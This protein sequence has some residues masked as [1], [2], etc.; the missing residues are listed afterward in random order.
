MHKKN[1]FPFGRKAVIVSRVS[2]D[3]QSYE[4][5]TQD[6][7]TWAKDNGYE[8]VKEFETKESGFLRYDLKEG[9]NNVT[10][11]FDKHP[12]CRILLCTEISRLSRRKA[13]LGI[14]QEYLEKHTI[15]LII[16]DIN[17]RLFND[18]G[19][20]EPGNDMIFSLYASMA[21]SE[22]RQKKERFRRARE[23]YGFHGYAIGGKELF[24][25]TRCYTEEK[26][27][28]RHRSYYIINK[29]EAEEIK[30]IYRWY[31][32]GIEGNPQQTSVRAITLRCIEE[33]MSR[34]LHSKRNVNKCL[35]EQAYIG[36]KKTHNRIKNPEYWVYK[37]Y[38]EPKYKPSNSFEYRYPCIFETEEE[39]ALF[40]AV[41][42]R[43]KDNCTKYAQIN[44]TYVDKS[45]LHTTLLAR[46]IHCPKCGHP[47]HGEYR[48]R[49]GRDYFIYR[50]GNN[51]ASLHKCSFGHTEKMELLDGVIYSVCENEI[52][53][54]RLNDMDSN[55]R[56]AIQTREEGLTRLYQKKEELNTEKKGI[57]DY[58]FSLIKRS[59]IDRDYV[60]SKIEQETKTLD[61][62]E[63]EY[64][65]EIEKLSAEIADL[66]T[67]ISALTI[68]SEDK[69]KLRTKKE[70]Y[71]YLHTVVSSITI[72]Y[73]TPTHT[74]LHINYATG[75]AD[76]TQAHDRNNSYICLYK[77]THGCHKAA[78]I[79]YNELNDTKYD[80]SPGGV[81]IWDS[82]QNVFSSPV[83]AITLD[84]IYECAFPAPKPVV[85]YNSGPK[86]RA[87]L[88]EWE[89]RRLHPRNYYNVQ[90]LPI[91]FK[92][93][94]IYSEDRR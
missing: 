36:V 65:K 40:A 77:N 92:M 32:Y 63:A 91:Q 60:K 76:G 35:K 44:G 42:I 55:L 18:D 43:I 48:I 78:L 26:I 24:G 83:G 3:I 51:R 57:I 8:V 86:A 4:P 89:E 84:E 54:L 19:V 94:D 21:Q 50:C 82:E 22:M 14:I 45:S 46:L 27:S 61:K 52:N 67:R 41:Q 85:K 13:I 37:N 71:K 39:K 29:S 59:G 47:L 64:N 25:Y 17:F 10:D 69:D 81:M 12:D 2:T 79:M 53:F 73:A 72:D 11:F 90:I 31:I 70:Y 33:G 58:G 38:S 6:L 28:G 20:V 34:Y 74:V 80:Y 93:L 66:K 88:A 9:W 49:D 7:K 87:A 68:L 15:Q 16:K 75:T 1:S 5:Q 23:D 56:A 62:K 30:R